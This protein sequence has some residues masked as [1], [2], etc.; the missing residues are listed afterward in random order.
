[1]LWVLNLLLLAVAVL[2]WQKLR[3][4]KVSDSTAGIVWQRSHT[5]QIDRNR[6][7]RVDE[8]TI[9]LPNGDAAIRRDTD[10]DGWFDLRYVERRGMATR[11]EQVREEA[12]RR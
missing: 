11:L 6:D 12:P 4:R 1:M 2:L 9:R 8:E 10:L 5:T 7:G 3:W